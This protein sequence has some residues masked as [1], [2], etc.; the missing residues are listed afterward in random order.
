MRRKQ[1]VWHLRRRRRFFL[2]TLS[3]FFHTI[4]Y[5]C[6]R[7]KWHNTMPAHKFACESAVV[8]A[9]II[10][11]IAWHE[12]CTARSIIFSQIINIT[13]KLC[14]LRQFF[15]SPLLVRSFT[16]SSRFSFSF[17]FVFVF[18]VGVVKKIGAKI[19]KRR[20]RMENNKEEKKAEEEC[21]ARSAQV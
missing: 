11:Y 4:S 15:S 20:I 7:C 14:I 19:R 9:I 21:A 8:S 2:F 3:H 13:Y 17:V 18:G 16:H 12:S 10:L 1:T 5:N 6:M